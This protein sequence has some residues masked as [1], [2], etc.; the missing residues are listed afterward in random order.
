[1]KFQRKLL[2]GFALMVV[3]VL[4]IGVQ[5]VWNNRE[6][7]AALR[8]LGES[9]AR[10]RT[11]AELE[12][13]LFRQSRQVWGF[14]TGI[15][16]EAQ[17]E[18]FRLEPEIQERLRQ[19][20]LTLTP[21]EL[22]LATDVEQIHTQMF[23]VGKQIIFLYQG[24]QRSAALA[25]AN[26]EIKSRLLPALS[27]KNKEIY[28]AARAH[29]LQRAYARLEE[30]LQAEQRLLSLIILLSLALGVAASILISRGLARPI[31]QLKAAMEVVGAGHLDH[32][33][34]VRS[35]DE[36]GELA[37]AFAGMTEN[38]KRSHKAMAHL[39][40]ELEAK[41]KKLE[42]TQAQLIQSEKLASI[43]EMS[44]AVAHGLR[45]P[46]A[47]LRAAAQVTLHHVGDERVAQEHLKMVIAEVDRLDRRISH[48]LA[49]SRPGPFR[50]LPEQLSRLIDDLLPAFAAPLKDRDIRLEIDLQ[51]NLPD[52]YVD[53]IQVEQALG[54]IFSNA[55]DAMPEGGSV[56]I[57]GYRRPDNGQP[58]CV[59]LQI[60]DTGN[61]IATQ[62][63]PSVCDP[64][65]TT[66]AEGTG[67]GLAIAKRYVVQNGGSLDI[68]S[69]PG[70]GTTVSIT[71]PTSSGNRDRTT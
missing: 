4:L 10:T 16:H 34:A 58:G 14:L 18:F 5:A 68:A 61:G 42:E 65:F 12:T 32:E 1:M 8:A 31:H 11:Y 6:E 50:P 59:V 37:Q 64:F 43:G 26:T 67:L 51:N 70:V 53:P 62:V 38:L 49:F 23:D 40:D 19:W 3:P 21:D 54:E 36:I 2:L 29:S 60:A 24:G 57:R 71:L 69:T 7:R 46:L 22:D 17:A 45:N 63:L 27:A 9:M 13:V 56:T 30:I 35:K 28:G 15:D 33:V 44:A 47:S 25:L 39:N 20:K 66:R 48:L 41:I 52:V 55:L